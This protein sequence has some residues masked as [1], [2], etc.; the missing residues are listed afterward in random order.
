MAKEEITEYQHKKIA[1]LRERIGEKK[2]KNSPIFNDDFSML[3]WLLGYD[4]KI[5]FIEF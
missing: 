4:Y 5:G 2:L 3:R 1:E